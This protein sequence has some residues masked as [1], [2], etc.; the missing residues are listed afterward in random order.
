[1]ELQPNRR[2][3]I[4]VST[5][6]TDKEQAFAMAYVAT[7][8]NITQAS[9][10]VGISRVTGTA[11]LKKQRVIDFIST[12]GESAGEKVA[13]AQEVLRYFTSVMRGE[14]KHQV[15]NAKTGFI[16]EV[17]DLHARNKA[18]EVLSKCYGLQ[19]EVVDLNQQT[20][21]HIG[22]NE[23]EE[24]EGYIE[25]ESDLKKLPNEKGSIEWK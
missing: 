2:G 13:D 7:S 23:D 11:Y 16:A 10:Q 15:V 25:M 3:R 8:G 4:N 19:R 1:M 17:D 14:I 21:F 9:T 5:G 22:F 6:L 24:E 20:V 12:L 18:G